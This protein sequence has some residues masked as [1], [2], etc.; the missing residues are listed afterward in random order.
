MATVRDIVTDAYRVSGIIGIT[1]TPSSEEADFGL[2]GLQSMF[3]SWIGNAMFGEFT[4]KYKTAAYT[5]L[6]GERVTTSGSPTITRPTTYEDGGIEYG[7]GSGERRAP[8]ELSVI[9][10][11][12]TTAGTEATYI[13]DR[14]AWVEIEAL[15]LNST[16]PLADYGERGLAM[17]LAMELCAIPAF[18]GQVTPGVMR[19]AGAFKSAVR[20]RR[21]ATLGPDAETAFY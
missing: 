20:G 15:T 9:Q 6:E 3:Q 14:G 21:Y 10:V 17:C 8:R 18:N 4:D 11:I 16:C 2:T 1:A 5:A 12:D 13:F 19:G 7:D